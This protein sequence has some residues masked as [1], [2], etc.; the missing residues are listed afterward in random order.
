L[1][2]GL[3]V[4]DLETTVLE[5]INS[6]SSTEFEVRDRTGR[7]YT[8]RIHPYR[9]SEKNVEGVVVVLFDVDDLKR[10]ID[11]AEAARQYAEGI[12]A[13]VRAQL[14]VL[15]A[16]LRVMK[17]N[18]SF[19][20]T[21]AVSPEDTEQRLVYEL[22]NHRGT[23]RS[24]AISSSGSCQRTVSSQASRWSMSFRRSGSVK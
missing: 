2:L 9:T 5:V 20:E 8:L 19:Y 4:S 11:T 21:F 22:G 16:S 17:A 14:L 13:T 1:R 10:S 23:S 18:R 15:D 7:W 3:D 6:V 12:I 24:F